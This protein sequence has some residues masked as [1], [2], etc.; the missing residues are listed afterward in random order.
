[1][2]RGFKSECES[3]AAAVR[4]EIGLDTRVPLDSREL[5]ASLDIPVHPISE[6]RGSADVAEAVE[7][8]LGMERSVISAMTIFPEWP[9]RRRVIIYNDS[10]S[11]GRQNS[12]L[13]HELSHGLLLHE[14]RHAIVNGCRNYQ[15]DEEDEANWLAGCLLVPRDAA[16]M[17]AMNGTAFAVAAE[18]FRVSEQ[19]MRFRVNGTGA[20][21]QAKAAKQR[22]AS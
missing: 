14:P 15:K 9:R 4:A 21:R 20:A 13:A 1:M 17:V 12:D 8:V 19:M 22:R 18:E 2:R 11:A 6:L 7:H 16:L 3:L 5:A 10:H